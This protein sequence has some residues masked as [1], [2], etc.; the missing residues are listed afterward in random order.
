VSVLAKKH[1]FGSEARFAGQGS[2]TLA[3]CARVSLYFS[4]NSHQ[5]STMYHFWWLA[6]NGEYMASRRLRASN[7][8][9]RDE[10]GAGYNP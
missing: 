2:Q 10:V 6:Y 1:V 9:N 5:F 4:F 8:S 3:L 7:L